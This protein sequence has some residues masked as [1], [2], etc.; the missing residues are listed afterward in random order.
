[1][2]CSPATLRALPTRR[3][4]QLHTNVVSVYERLHANSLRTTMQILE[5]R[6]MKT[7]ASAAAAAGAE[8]ADGDLFG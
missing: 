5:Q 6:V 3:V 4:R 1:M 2:V 8:V 7:A